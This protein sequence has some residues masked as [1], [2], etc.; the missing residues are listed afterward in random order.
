[1]S[2]QSSSGAT[3]R[4]TIRTHLRLGANPAYLTAA[5][6]N[7]NGGHRV[8]AGTDIMIQYASDCSVVTAQT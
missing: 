8:V 5:T 1:M 7:N 3:R 2:K 6:K 4:D